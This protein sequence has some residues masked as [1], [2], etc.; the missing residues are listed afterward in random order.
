MV[1]GI[2]VRR[3]IKIIS[4][5]AL[6]LFIAACGMGGGHT[7]S[8]N[9]GSVGFSITWNPNGSASSAIAAKSASSVPQRIL[10]GDV[11]VDYGVDTITATLKDST[12]TAIASGD[13]SCSTHGGTF[14]NLAYQSN[15]SL[16]LDGKYNGV[17]Y[18]HGQTT[19]ISVYSSTPVQAGVT[20]TP[21][22]LDT[23][24]PT[25]PS[26]LT[27]TANGSGQVNLAW[28][29]STDNLIVTRYKI[30]RQGTYT[31]VAS[32]TAY[33]DSGLTASTQYC[34]NVTAVDASGNESLQSTQSCAT[35]GAFTGDTTAPT[36]P[37]GLTASSTSST[38]I[39]LAW[40][41]STDNRSVAGYKIYKGGAYLM[42]AIANTSAT[43]SGLTASTQYCYQVSAYDPS[44]NESSKTTPEVC[45]TTL[46]TGTSDTMAPGS[47]FIE[48][49][50]GASSTTSTSVLL[51][52]AATDDVGTRAIQAH[53]I[54]PIGRGDKAV[55]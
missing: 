48:I 14:T 9:R 17:L 2:G 29:A 3:I 35:T 54:A 41:A 37:Y 4:I 52:L 12:N 55:G 25:T 11:C 28:T 51:A 5:S 53:L 24:A 18:W 16:S 44:G 38:A 7:D 6:A 40:G 27:T 34:Y 42:S 23:A 22:T 50:A 19:G 49:N 10:T 39:N 15:L 21:L 32:S 30:Y 26:G 43:D 36:V 8:N 46:A 20:M 31:G 1:R 13:F 33:S 47:P 45:A